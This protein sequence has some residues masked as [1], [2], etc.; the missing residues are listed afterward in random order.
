LSQAKLAE[1]ILQDPSIIGK[2]CKG[3]RLTGA[4]ASERVVAIVGW[5]RAQGV[6]VDHID[7]ERRYRLLEPVRQFAHAHRAAISMTRWRHQVAG[8]ERDVAAARSQ[9]NAET[10][11]AKWAIGCAMTLEQAVEYALSF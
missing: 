5:L 3:E 11:G 8:Y 10:W 2:M 9:L 1:G 7:G 6:L 4:Q